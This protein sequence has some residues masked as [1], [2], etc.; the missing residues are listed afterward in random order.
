[1]DVVTDLIFTPLG[2][3]ICIGVAI[4]YFVWSSSKDYDIWEKKGVPYVKPKPFFGSPLHETEVDNYKKYGRLYGSFVGSRPYLSVGDPEH[5]RNILVKDFQFFSNRQGLKTGDKITERMLQLLEGEDWK[6]VRT[7]VTP[8]FTTGKIK[9]GSVLSSIS[10]LLMMSIFTSCSK[11]LVENFRKYAKSG[12]AVDS[13]KIYGA[14]TMDII[15]SAA[16]ST[17]LD[18]HNDPNN[19]FVQIARS[20]F[21]HFNYR[22]VFYLLVPRIMRFFKVPIFPP[23]G[24]KFFTDVTLRIIQERKRTG[25][26][27]NDFLQL[28]MD[29]ADEIK[30][31]DNISEK[32]DGTLNN[33][34]TETNDQV[35][36]NAQSKKATLTTEELIAQCVIF[37]LA[38]FETTA[39]TLSF[40]SYYLAL[41]PD[42]QDRLVEELDEAVRAG[43]GE[44]TYEAVQSMKYLDNV[45]SE[46]LRIH[47]PAVRLDRLT[48]E[49]YKLGDT[50]VVI[51]KD[52]VVTVPIY[53]M[54]RDP[55]FFPDP[56]TFKPDRF[57]AE[58]RSKRN[59]YTF[60][61]F[62]AGPRNCV[63]M[64]FALVEVKVSLAYVLSNFRIK[65]CPQ[66]KVP[67][68]Y[69]IGQGLLQPK[70][71][72]IALEERENCLL[73]M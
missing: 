34:D 20:V 47:P 32:S 71:V 29:T 57:A 27:R 63:G 4:F 46:T 19:E 55:D 33:Y 31:E 59:P 58:E 54:H 49:D 11:V 21:H 15:A 8:T 24:V 17:K 73:K 42:I 5:L 65:R 43:N 50:G 14:F 10:H 16:F 25:Q 61:P 39:S 18:S 41:N 38:G 53:A 37:F 26:K 67:L 35:F 56:E 70:D 6:R 45:I 48:G 3:A 30:A 2:A 60:M 28:L 7:I 68:D 44:L 23:K 52:T 40:V 1:M 9:K 13:K 62:G 36:K 51:P 22:F 72:T 12:E 69:M 66:T 64:R